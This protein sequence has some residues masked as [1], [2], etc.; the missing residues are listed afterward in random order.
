MSSTRSRPRRDLS[1]QR[2]GMLVARERLPMLPGTQGARW[3][4]DCD[5]GGSTV[6][7]AKDLPNRNTRS[8]GC[9]TNRAR[10]AAEQ[11]HRAGDEDLYPRVREVVLATL[12]TGGSLRQDRV[13]SRFDG[14]TSR[15]TLYRFIRRAIAEHEAAGEDASVA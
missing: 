4:C 1:D 15:S 12:G 5:C 6:V 10:V 3:R 9:L 14:M 7:R 13:R 11:P 2:F 8:C